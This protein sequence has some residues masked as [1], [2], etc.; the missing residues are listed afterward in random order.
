MERARAI[1][2]GAS[3]PLAL[4][5]LWHV[6]VVSSGTML[7][8]TP[9]MVGVMMRD[10]AFG[11]VYDDAFSGTIVTHL[12]ASMQRVYGGFFLAIAIGIGAGWFFYDRKRESLFVRD[13]HG[14]RR[15]VDPRGQHLAGAGLVDLQPIARLV[16]KVQSH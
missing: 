9:G 16:I 13:P 8:P 11:G 10:F 5:A 3:F 12:L 1:L 2:L 4:V 6:S 14:V 15:G 7:V